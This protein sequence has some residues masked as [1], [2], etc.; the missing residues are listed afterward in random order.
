MILFNVLKIWRNISDPVIS[1]PVIYPVKIAIKW[2]NRCWNIMQPVAEG[3]RPV[4]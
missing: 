4:H 2:P 3:G 1:F